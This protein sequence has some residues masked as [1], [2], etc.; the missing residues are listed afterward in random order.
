MPELD[1]HGCRTQ[2][3]LSYL[4]A[5]G[6]LRLV[7][8]QS[9]PEAR[10]AWAPAG[11]ARLATRLD[12]DGLTAF[13]MDDYAPTP[14]TSPWNGGSG[15]YPGDNTDA[16]RAIEAGQSPRLASMR[17]T[18]AAA[19]ALVARL[20]EPAA[21]KGDAKENLLR[22]WRAEAPDAALEWLDAATVLT[23]AGVSMNPLLGTGGNDGRLEFS[24]NYMARLGE[25]LPGRDTAP[26]DVALERSR[27]LLRR[28][29]TDSGDAPYGTSKVGMF[30]PALSGM[31]NSWSTSDPAT[32]SSLLNPWDFVLMLEGSVLFAG[33]VGRRLSAQEALFPFTVTAGGVERAGRSMADEGARGETWLPVWRQPARLASVARLLAEG[34]A[35]DGRSQARSGRAMGRATTTLGVERG[36]EEFQRVVYAERFGR[37]YVA[38]PVD[39]VRVRASRAVELQRSTDAWVWQTRRLPGSA[40]ASAS[41]RLDIA[42]HATIADELGAFE[43]WLLALSHLEL[44]VAR[45]AAAGAETRVNPLQNL[46]GDIVSQL[47]DTPEVRLA[48]ALARALAGSEKRTAVP[49]VRVALEPLRPDSRGRLEW[50]GRKGMGAAGLR[51]PLSTLIEMAQIT[52][53]A[54][55]TGFA[56][57]TDVAAFLEGRL[58]DERI[59]ALTFALS[60]CKL[61]DSR[62]AGGAQT[63]SKGLDRVYAATYLATR[64]VETDAANGRKLAAQKTPEIIPA[65]AAGSVSHAVG[66]AL[67]R[68][69][70]DGLRPYPALRECRRSPESARRIA[71][72]LAIPLHPA[73][74]AALETAALIPSETSGGN[75]S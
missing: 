14:I 20:P 63:H 49:A 1:L 8:L 64:T 48:T 21:P 61:A 2:P 22:Q 66:L 51:A 55:T 60:L 62:G 47:D 19:R 52:T 74:R 28:A 3:L 65:L 12:E 18:I 32:D 72:A 10:L 40:I 50:H 53:G 7:G 54:G 13:F 45:L 31:P 16:L 42:A 34:R 5:L 27:G 70:A 4:K 68:L 41:R 33:S 46:S 36:I 30:A 71:A 17:E 69:R 38:V 23:D 9:D 26:P 57:L 11:H 58:D 56:R 35:Q 29:L 37:N 73:D 43:R 67:T 39:R 6:V 24:N 59:L 44:A 75:G 15:Y 25:C